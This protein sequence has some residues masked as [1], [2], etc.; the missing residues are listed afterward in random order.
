MAS[1]HQFGGHWTDDKLDRLRKYLAAY[2]RIFTVNSFAARYKTTFVDA[3]AGTGYRNLPKHSKHEC[4]PMLLEDTPIYDE[5]A[6]SFQKGSA[7]IALETDP[8]FNHYLFIEQNR[9]YVRELEV[10][11]ER[12][13]AIADRVEI[14]QG[15][16]N[17]E[18][19]DWCRRVDWRQNRA[20]V[21]LDP[22]GMEV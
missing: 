5:E 9:E 14:R 22:Y 7:Q 10:L 16:A 11:R 17:S 6:Q 13:S 15:E 18:L 1:T 20:V 2:I 19:Q 4:I 3:F 12:F 8:P 21:F